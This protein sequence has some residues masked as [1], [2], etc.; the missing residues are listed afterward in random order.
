MGPW[1]GYLP[2]WAVT[3]GLSRMFKSGSVPLAEAAPPHA[4]RAS[5]TTASHR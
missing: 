1:H 5:C 4:V 2:T 3:Q